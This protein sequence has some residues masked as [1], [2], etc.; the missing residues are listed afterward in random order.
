L[1]R[2]YSGQLFLVTNRTF[3]Q[4]MK[5]MHACIGRFYGTADAALRLDAVPSS[6]SSS[7]DALQASVLC[8]ARARD[9]GSKLKESLSSAWS[10]G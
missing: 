8:A 6:S 4:G 7:S 5:S 9:R 10:C 3:E 1:N 2:L